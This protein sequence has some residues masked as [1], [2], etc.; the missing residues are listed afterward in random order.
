[1]A[2]LPLPDWKACL[3]VPKLLLEPDW[4]IFRLLPPD[5]LPSSC[6]TAAPDVPTVLL[7]PDWSTLIVCASPVWLV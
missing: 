4:V 7:V 5:P 1:M 6:K 3:A 2:E